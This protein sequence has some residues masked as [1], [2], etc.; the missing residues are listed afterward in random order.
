MWKDT[1]NSWNSFINYCLLNKVA[2]LHKDVNLSVLCLAQVLPSSLVLRPPL[3]PPRTTIPAV[4]PPSPLLLLKMN[5]RSLLLLTPSL[6]NRTRLIEAQISQHGR[7]QAP[8]L[9]HLPSSPPTPSL[10]QNLSPRPL[11]KTSPCL[12][13][14]HGPL[15]LLGL[16]RSRTARPPISAMGTLTQ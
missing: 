2:F 1:Q 15:L 9:P 8:T 10:T 12:R 16:P 5:P 11:E 3:L 7:S 4:N 6:K 13:L 14:R